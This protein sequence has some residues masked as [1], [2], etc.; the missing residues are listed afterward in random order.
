MD[1]APVLASRLQKGTV[2]AQCALYDKRN[3]AF[4]KSCAH[5]KLRW[6]DCVSVALVCRYSTVVS[7]HMCDVCVHV[8]S[9]NSKSYM[10][11]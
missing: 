8:R 3:I 6:H 11:M 9:R 2:S 10:R 7:T 5:A 1:Y 4:H